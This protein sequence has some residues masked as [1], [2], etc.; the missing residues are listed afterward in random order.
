MNKEVFKDVFILFFKV[1]LFLL[2]LFGRTFI[3]VNIFGYRL[4]E[5]LVGISFLI[6]FVCVFIF[7]IYKKT[8]FLDDKKINLV[9]GI[10]F[11]SFVIINFLNRTSFT[12]LFIYQT[13]TYIWSIGALVFGYV[14][15]DY[16]PNLIKKEDVLLSLI[17]MFI[18]YIFST[19][20][21]SENLQ[22]V[23]LIYTDKFEYPKG[24]DLL[25]A[26]IF[27]MYL[28]INKLNFSRK[29]FIILL[30]ISALYIPLFLVKSRS[31]FISIVLF[32]LLILPRYKQVLKN[33]D[34]KFLIPVGLTVFIF[35]SSTSYVVSKNVVIDE[36]ISDELKFAITSR[37]KTI[38]DNKY[39]REVLELSL[40]YFQNGRIFTTDG[41]LNWRFQ[42]W[43]DVLKD[44]YDDEKIILGYGFDDIIPAMD[45][46]Q[47]TGQDQQNINVHNYFVHILSRGGVIH[48]F[49]VLIFYVYLF[50]KLKSLNLQN[51]FLSLTIPLIFNSLFDPSMENAHYPLIFY[52]TVGLIIKK[53]ILFRGNIKL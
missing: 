17:G 7:P 30:F 36:T 5:M 12:N 13:S 41:N 18:I 49:S 31:G 48:L 9:L 20:G 15:L 42:I 1:F 32:I 21:I 2:F 28:I 53:P 8:Y 26:F 27:I 19:R 52:F 35:L 6:F 14:F 11:V 51:D 37:Y 50:R 38:N 45:S 10:L 22:N 33:L 23:F 44:M 16:F 3:G 43:Q 24:S 46:D 39:E 47:R 40:F 4:G 29:S 25:I 34:Y